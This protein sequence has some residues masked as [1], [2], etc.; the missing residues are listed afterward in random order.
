[1]RTPDTFSIVVAWVIVSSTASLAIQAWICY[2]CFRAFHN[3]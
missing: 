1:M 2:Q 3:F